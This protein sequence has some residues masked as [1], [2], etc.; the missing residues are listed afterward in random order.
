VEA[1]IQTD[2]TD[3]KGCRLWVSS[4]SKTLTSTSFSKRVV[5]EELLLHEVLKMDCNVGETAELLTTME[6]VASVSGS[7]NESTTTY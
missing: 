7:S 2:L 4:I 1:P 5:L 3:F 6:V